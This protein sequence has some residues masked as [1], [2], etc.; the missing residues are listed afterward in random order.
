MGQDRHGYSIDS[1]DPSRVGSGKGDTPSKMDLKEPSNTYPSGHM[2]RVDP[3]ISYSTTRRREQ[4][5]DH[6]GSDTETPFSGSVGS[7]ISSK[8]P[9]ASTRT[10]VDPRTSYHGPGP[11]GLSKTLSEQSVRGQ[12]AASSDS[13]TRLNQKGKESALTSAQRTSSRRETDVDYAGGDQS[14]VRG[15]RGEGGAG[16]SGQPQPWNTSKDPSIA[17]HQSVDTRPSYRGPDPS[18]LSKTVSQPV[19]GSASSVAD[20]GSQS[21]FVRG[22]P[23]RKDPQSTVNAINLRPWSVIHFIV[24]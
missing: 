23:W 16:T 22:L 1:R 13:Q 19:V 5:S 2:D 7:R 8:I 4:D 15:Y 21:C 3:R 14:L 18:S 24:C 17:A 10:T 11:S 20:V 9:S 6:S 12:P